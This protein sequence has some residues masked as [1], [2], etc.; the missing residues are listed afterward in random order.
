M[1]RSLESA[2]IFGATF[3]HV[4]FICG[5]Q[6][7]CESICHKAMSGLVFR[8]FVELSII[9]LSDDVVSRFN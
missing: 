7:K 9:V 3:L 6:V 4:L 8:I 1:Y 2:P 5:I